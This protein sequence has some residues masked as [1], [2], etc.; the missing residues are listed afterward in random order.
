VGGPFR[1][2]DCP[3]RILHNTSV[4]KGISADS[5]L[6]AYNEFVSWTE[7]FVHCERAAGRLE[8]DNIVAIVVDLPV[9]KIR[10]KMI[11]RWQPYTLYAWTL[12]RFPSV[13][14]VIN[15]LASAPRRVQKA[16]PVQIPTNRS[17]WGLAGGRKHH[18]CVDVRGR[19]SLT[20]TCQVDI[21]PLPDR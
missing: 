16:R 21:D 7:G 20:V 8:V 19:I 1:S 11:G 14:V 10:R 9:T 3:R 6:E 15:F 2:Q 13:C 4:D 18:P 17:V 12:E 5:H